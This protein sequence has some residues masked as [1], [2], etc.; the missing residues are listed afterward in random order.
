L[1]VL[2]IGQDYASLSA[3]VD[4][5]EQQ[6]TTGQTI[7]E[8]PQ[9]GNGKLSRTVRR[10]P[11]GGNWFDILKWGRMIILTL[12]SPEVLENLTSI[13]LEDDFVLSPEELRFLASLNKLGA[14]RLG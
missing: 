4:Y 12:L 13:E 6:L 10:Y 9:A 14:V 3:A 8:L 7:C 5:A 1:N 11:V 2:T